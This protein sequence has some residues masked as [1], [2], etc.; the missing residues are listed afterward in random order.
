[1]VSCRDTVPT[2]V[3]VMMT[4]SRDWNVT[5]AAIKIYEWVFLRPL[6]P[7][8]YHFPVKEREIDMSTGTVMRAF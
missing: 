5:G 2:G 6:T 8:P 4:L 7:V 1:M 3:L